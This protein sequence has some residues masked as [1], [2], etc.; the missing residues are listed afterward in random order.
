MIGV[1]DIYAAGK[2]VVDELG[3]IGRTFTGA[4]GS[5]R[6]PWPSPTGATPAA[7]VLTTLRL[8]VMCARMRSPAASAL[9]K[10]SSPAITAL[11]TMRASCWAFWPG[12]VGCAPLMPRRLRTPPW[13]ARTVPPPTVPTS[14]EGMV[15]VIRRSRSLFTLSENMS[16]SFSRQFWKVTHASIPVRHIELSTTWAGSWP[17]AKNTAAT[18]LAACAL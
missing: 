13:G 8:C 14:I 4:A 2:G 17:V 18:I 1:L 12:C 3:V 11:A 15:T 6:T 16:A 9:I 5:T 7:G 10:L